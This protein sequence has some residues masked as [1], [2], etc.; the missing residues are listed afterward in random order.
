VYWRAPE[1]CVLSSIT[2]TTS[3][4]IAAD[5]TN[6]ATVTATNLGSAGAGTTVVATRTTDSDVTGSGAIVAKV[7]W[8]LI[9]SATAANLEIEAGDVLEIAF[10][11]GGTAASGDMTNVTLNINTIPGAGIGA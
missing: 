4:G 11:E 9:N 7:P 3:T 10:T 2:V 5:K 6:I 8:T 1:R